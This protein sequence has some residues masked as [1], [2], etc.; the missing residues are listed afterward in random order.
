M[1]L[2][3]IWWCTLSTPFLLLPNSL[4]SRNAVMHPSSSGFFPPGQEDPSWSKSGTFSARLIPSLTMNCQPI[5]QPG[6][7]R[8]QILLYFTLKPCPSNWSHFIRPLLS[9]VPFTPEGC[10][11]GSRDSRGQHLMSMGNNHCLMPLLAPTACGICWDRSC[12][13]GDIHTNTIQMEG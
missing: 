1:G 8:D 10:Q 13:I 7:P 12:R 2:E 4:A 11:L 6:P 9:H 5:S 3:L